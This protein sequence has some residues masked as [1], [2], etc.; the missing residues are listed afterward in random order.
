MGIDTDD[1]LDRTQLLQIISG[2]R[3][4]PLAAA[5]RVIC[6]TLTPVYRLAIGIRNRRFDRNPDQAIQRGAIPV[7]SIGN[8]T[9]GGTGKTP[10]VVYVA[11]FLRQLDQ[12]VVV[13][14]RGYQGSK[15]SAGGRNDEAIELEMRLPDVPHL[16]D[17]DRYRMVSVAVDELA[18]QIAVL[19]DGFQHR[20]LYRDVDMV[21]I[22]AT[23]PFGFDRLLPRGLLRE[24]ITSLARADI[25]IITRCQLST[26]AN[27]KQIETRIRAVAP[28]LPIA[29][30]HTVPHA[31]IQHDGREIPIAALGDEPVF[32]FC[33]IGNPVGFLGTLSQLGTKLVGQQTFEDHHPFSRADL[34]GL[35]TA[36]RDAGATALV[37]T[38]KDLVKLG[39]NQFREL[40]IYALQIDLEIVSGEQAIQTLLKDAVSAAP[41]G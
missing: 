27:I 28:G 41:I 20:Q 1:M 26:A 4:G 21:L 32:A 35:A 23:N 17:P 37:C 19:D 34:E 31:W 30:T 3:T 16:Q 11:K 15:S 39:V 18:S 25:A 40:P 29:H 13:I 7:I 33:G 36:A 6:G 22:D 8:L 24:P 12:R 2:E 9:T 14:S 38:H 5:V 10:L